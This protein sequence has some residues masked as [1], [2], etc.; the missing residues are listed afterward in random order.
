[1]AEVLLDH[2]HD[3]DGMQTSYATTGQREN[4]EGH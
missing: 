2:I 1:M 4:V 3:V